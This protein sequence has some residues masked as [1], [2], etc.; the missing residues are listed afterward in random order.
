MITESA[1]KTKW[2]PFARGVNER[3]SATPTT[4]NRGNMGRPDVDCLCI[5]LECMAWRQAET[6]EFKRKADETFRKYGTRLVADTG[7]CGLAGSPVI[8]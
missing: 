7:Y 5:A 8:P 2:C 1:A 6:A 4:I 3:D